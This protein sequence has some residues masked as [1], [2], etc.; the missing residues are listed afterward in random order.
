[1][2]GDLDFWT[3]GCRGHGCRVVGCFRPIVCFR[4]GGCVKIECKKVGVISVIIKS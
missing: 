1:M 4:V 3:R 2:V